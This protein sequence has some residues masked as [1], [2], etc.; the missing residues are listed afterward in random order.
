LNK[1]TALRSTRRRR[2]YQHYTHAPKSVVHACQPVSGISC[3]EGL[4]GGA[5]AVVTNETFSS[6]ILSTKVQRLST[7]EGNEN[8]VEPL[9]TRLSYPMIAATSRPQ[10]FYASSLTTNYK[11]ITMTERPGANCRSTK[12]RV[13]VVNL[14][15]R[16]RQWIKERGLRKK[17]IKRL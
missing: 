1:H 3:V 2:R 14:F 7:Q 6:D 11:L 9:T 8:V 12:F 10:Y 5:V 4:S 15:L 17:E 16:F 13:R